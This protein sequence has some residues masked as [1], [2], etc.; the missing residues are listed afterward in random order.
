MVAFTV[1]KEGVEPEAVYAV[2]RHE[3][4][5]DDIKTAKQTD[6]V[7]IATFFS[8]ESAKLCAMTHRIT[9]GTNDQEETDE[10]E[11]AEE[12]TQEDLAGGI[13]PQGAN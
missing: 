6:A 8:E 13:D 2:V 4:D 1:E 7:T 3:F 5:G 12:S 11:E 9:E 10:I